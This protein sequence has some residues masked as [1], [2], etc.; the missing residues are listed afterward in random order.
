M[1]KKKCS[2]IDK[3][4]ALKD[5]ITLMSNAKEPYNS[6]DVE[7]VKGM[8]IPPIELNQFKIFYRD[9]R[10]VGYTTW[11]FFNKETE[12]KLTDNEEYL[13]K[14]D[15]NSGDT[16]WHVDTVCNNI[17][18]LKV[19]RWT[20]SNLKKIIGIGKKVYWIRLN[21]DGSLKRLGWGITH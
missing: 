8:I 3:Y 15:W 4:I 17:S 16:C 1:Q 21:E 20:H 6:M 12:K 10:P 19:H 9:K 7:Y 11:G 18:V 14:N 2:C 5:I 13:T